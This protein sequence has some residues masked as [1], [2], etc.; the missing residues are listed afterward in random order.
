MD[1]RRATERSRAV[2]LA[3]TTSGTAWCGKGAS[4]GAASYSVRACSAGCAQCCARLRGSMQDTVALTHALEVALAGCRRCTGCL[5]PDYPRCGSP[6]FPVRL[7]RPRLA[8]EK[9]TCTPCCL[10]AHRVFMCCSFFVC[11]HSCFETTMGHL[12]ISL[13]MMLRLQVVKFATPV[14]YGARK[15]I[16]SALR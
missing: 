1:M 6:C 3:P 9:T 14:Y 5:H 7:P 13:L 2:R 8:G 11:S 12:S 16:G 10:Q 15:S 4:C